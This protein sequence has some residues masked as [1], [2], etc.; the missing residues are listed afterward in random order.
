MTTCTRTIRT[1][2][3]SRINQHDKLVQLVTQGV[4]AALIILNQSKAYDVVSQKLLLR[5]LKVIR[6]DNQA[7]KVMENFLSEKK[8]FFQ[9]EGQCF[10]KL[11]T[12]PQ[13]V[14]QG[15]SL[16]CIMFLIFILDMPG[17]FHQAATLSWRTISANN[18]T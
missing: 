12:R 8:Q 5:K 10:Q 6:F 15:S 13:S 7:M 1:T 3:Q 14:I 9:V 11:L 16:N 2:A 17:L 4:E 18:P